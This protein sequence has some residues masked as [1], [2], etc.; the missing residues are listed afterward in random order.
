MG[1]LRNWEELTQCFSSEDRKDIE[2][3]KAKIRLEIA[4]SKQKRPLSLPKQTR[5]RKPR[6]IGSER[7]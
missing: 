2:E 3:E 5:A 4:R 1:G 6:A 7:A